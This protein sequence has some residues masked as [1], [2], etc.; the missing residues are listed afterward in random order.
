MLHVRAIFLA[1]LYLR[2]SRPEP[3]RILRLEGR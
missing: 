1:V 2:S 3:Q